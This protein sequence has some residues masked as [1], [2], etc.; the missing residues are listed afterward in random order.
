[1]KVVIVGGT[2]TLGTAL[3]R[4]LSPE[5]EVI[6]ISRDELKQ[7]AARAVFPE[8]RFALADVRDR[9]SLDRHFSGADVVFH[10]AALKHVDLIEDNP[11]EAGEDERARNDQCCRSSSSGA[12]ATRRL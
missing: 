7:Q 12:G 11:E 2:G 8:V 9:S 1:M 6:V 10:V 5:H 3:C 4:R